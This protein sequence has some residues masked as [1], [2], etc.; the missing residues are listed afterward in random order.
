MIQANYIGI[1]RYFAN[2]DG[3]IYDLCSN[4]LIQP[5]KQKLSQWYVTDG[6]EY[7]QHTYLLT[8]YSNKRYSLEQL[9]D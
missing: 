9:D 5:D 6:T 2:I 3:T 7:P 8:I 4:N 1:S